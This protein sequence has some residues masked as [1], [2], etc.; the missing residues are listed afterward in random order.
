[1]N[2]FIQHVFFQCSTSSRE[3]SSPKTDSTVSSNQD[4]WRFHS[5]LWFFSWLHPFAVQ[6]LY[7][8]ISIRTISPHSRC[9]FSEIICY[10]KQFEWKFYFCIFHSSCLSESYYI[11]SPCE[12]SSPQSRKTIL[13]TLSFADLPKSSMTNSWKTKGN[14]ITLVMPMLSDFFEALFEVMV[15]KSQYE[16][17]KRSIFPSIPLSFK[18]STPSVSIVPTSKIHRHKLFLEVS[19]GLLVIDKCF[20]ALRIN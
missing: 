11:K 12:I 5:T 4:I 13:K 6:N 3:R 7:F 17:N 1:M 19:L 9:N 15:G 14:Q 16:A 10:F 2:P 18:L 20:T 8:S